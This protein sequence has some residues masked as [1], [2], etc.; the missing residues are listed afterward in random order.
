MSGGLPRDHHHPHLSS[1]GMPIATGGTSNWQFRS[2]LDIGTPVLY[3]N[4]AG[5]RRSGSGVAGARAGAFPASQRGEAR[6]D[7]GFVVPLARS[8]V[9]TRCMRGSEMCSIPCNDPCFMLVERGIT[10]RRV[11]LPF[12]GFNPWEAGPLVCRTSISAFRFAQ[13]CRPWERVLL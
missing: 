10:A 3:V 8:R 13:S 2:T 9:C 7:G 11:N 5:W 4:R 6:K 12:A 1:C